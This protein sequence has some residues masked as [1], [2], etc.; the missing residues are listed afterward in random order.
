MSINKKSIEKYEK[1]YAGIPASILHL[2]HLSLMLFM[3]TKMNGG[4]TFFPCMFLE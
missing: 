2:L 4:S 1:A 3:I